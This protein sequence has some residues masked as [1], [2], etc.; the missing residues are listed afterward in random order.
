MK[1]RGPEIGVVLNRYGKTCPP[2]SPSQCAR[3]SNAW[4]RNERVVHSHYF[5]A[6][7]GRST[8]K[9][10]GSWTRPLAALF[11]TENFFLAHCA[12]E[13]IRS[14]SPFKQVAKRTE[15]E[16]RGRMGHSMHIKYSPACLQWCPSSTTTMQP[17]FC[18]QKKCQE[19]CRGTGV[20]SLR[21]PVLAHRKGGLHR[22]KTYQQSACTLGMH[23]FWCTYVLWANYANCVPQ[24]AAQGTLQNKHFPWKRLGR[25]HR[26]AT[27]SVPFPL[28]RPHF[29]VWDRA[30]HRPPKARRPKMR[31][32][33]SE[34]LITLQ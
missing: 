6:K 33:S 21:K 16:A 22:G 26:W 13:F 20:R 10:G 4:R 3:T 25:T 12:G 7:K 9:G 18:A 11:R 31:C 5:R 32:K 29:Y 34:I 24:G 15:R 30:D 14:L 1:R 23:V 17:Q 28:L 27:S 2:P 19:T 8:K